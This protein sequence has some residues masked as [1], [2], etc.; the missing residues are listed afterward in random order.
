MI[1]TLEG[2]N[3]WLLW[4]NW[5]SSQSKQLLATAK[6]IPCIEWLTGSLTSYHN[7]FQKEKQA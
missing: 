4:S 3:H 7:S 2:C 6:L 5:S 1:L